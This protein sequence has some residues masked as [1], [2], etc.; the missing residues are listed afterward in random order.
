MRDVLEQRAPQHLFRAAENFAQPRIDL[1]QLTVERDVR[2]AHPGALES[3]PKAQLDVAQ[4]LLARRR[5]RSR[6]AHP[7]CAEHF[8]S[9]ELAATAR[10]E[11]RGAVRASASTPTSAP[12]W[13]NGVASN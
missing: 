2:D 7:P 8:A 3:A 6:A 5:S 4:S 10:I 9:G 13:R 12:W 11:T 1:E